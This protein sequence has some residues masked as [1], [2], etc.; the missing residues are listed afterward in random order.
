MLKF[1]YDVTSEAILTFTTQYNQSENGSPGSVAGLKNW[2]SPALRA[3]LKLD[4]MIFNL[5]YGMRNIFGNAD[6]TVNTYHHSFRTRFDDP[7]TWGGPT[8]SDHKNYAYGIDLA[9]NNPVSELITLTYGYIYRH[10]EAT[11]SSIGE[12]NRNTHSAHASMN[13]GLKEIDFYF[14]NISII[15]AVRY[16]AP[17]DFDK[18]F[19]PKVSLILASKDDYALSLS[20]HLSKSYRAPTFNDLYWPEDAF[21]VGNPNLKPEKGTSFEFGYAITL[22]FL[23]RTQLKI[24]YFTNEISDQ[25]IWAPRAD[26]KW[27]PTNVEKS[28]TS[29]LETY[30]GTKFFD[31][32]L[33][34]EFNHTYMDARDAS[35]KVNDGKLLIYRPY[36]KLDINSSIKIII[37]DFNINYQF[38]SQRYVDVANTA[39][40]PDLS[41]WNMNIGTNPELAG[42]KWN[43]RLDLNN[44]F[45]KD[46]RLSDGYPMPG[47]EI[48]MTVGLSLQ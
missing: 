35:G 43:F 24:N 38:L 18:I 22:P 4:N 45:N 29:G 10:D 40:L 46:Y 48:R 28:K 21:T 30:I 33:S 20:A 8:S 37:V 39:A 2:A 15:P 16:D 23:N 6:L 12:K 42:L 5:N 7:D 25:I 14:G 9:Q 1:G 19:S 17:S 13:I 3:R 47:R 32:I 26:F 41:L 34:L 44:I 36:H 11:S 31:E 27:T